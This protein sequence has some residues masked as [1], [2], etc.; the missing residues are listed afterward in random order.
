LAL[1]GCPRAGGKPYPGRRVEWQ[2]P[3][4]RKI[5]LYRRLDWSDFCEVA[6]GDSE[7]ARPAPERAGSRRRPP[8]PGFPL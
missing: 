4:G 3:K 7:L 1:Q 6:G 8:I 5:N 2:F